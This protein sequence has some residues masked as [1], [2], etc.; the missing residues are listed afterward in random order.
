MLE[1]W[2]TVTG[3]WHQPSNGMLVAVRAE[4]MVSVLGQLD[5]IQSVTSPHWV[6]FPV[7]MRSPAERPVW[8][9]FQPGG[10]A[11]GQLRPQEALLDTSP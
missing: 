1:S 3:L 8:Q 4:C 6:L 9:I 7:S 10:E 2:D 5:W 11:A